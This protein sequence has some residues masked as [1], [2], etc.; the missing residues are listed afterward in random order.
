MYRLLIVEDDMG[1]AEA[2]EKQATAWGL[3]VK[4]IKDFQ[5][6]M[7]EFAEFN[8]HLILMDIGLPFFDGYYWC[9]IYG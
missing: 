8:P 1:I 3:T 7:Q 9:S 5:S 6:V 4:C 2:I